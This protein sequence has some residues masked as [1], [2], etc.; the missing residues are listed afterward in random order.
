MI[1]L[2]SVMIVS[3]FWE[4]NLLLYP[5]GMENPGWW[6][7]ANQNVFLGGG[8]DIFWNHTFHEQYSGEFS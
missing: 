1:S 7:C 6:G 5:P 3:F 2:L 4:H 8:M